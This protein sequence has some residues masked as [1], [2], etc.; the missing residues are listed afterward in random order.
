MKRWFLALAALTVLTG[1]AWAGTPYP[2]KMTCPV[3][4]EKFTHTDTMSSS[5]WGAR[6]DGKPYGSWIFPNPIPECPGNRLVVFK[7]FSKDEIKALTPLLETPAYRALWADTTY[8]RLAWLARELGVK[9]VDAGWVLLQASWQAD[10]D[11][12]RKARYQREFVAAVDASSGP[13]DLGTLSLQARAVNAE[14]ELG[15]FGA[16]AA[17]G[18]ALKARI[19]AVSAKPADQDQADNFKGLDDFVARLQVAIARKDAASEPL[20]LISP[21]V[22]ADR[23]LDLQ[24]KGTPDALCKAANLLELIEKQ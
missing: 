14:R 4:G 16:A 7:D 2:V 10:G 22:A 18:G 12:A 3:G 11:P 5:T 15:D 24:R 20:D 19:A 8:Y 13:D 1:P 6:P 17:R 21:R 23:C 9:D